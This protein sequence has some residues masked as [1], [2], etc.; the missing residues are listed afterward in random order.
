MQHFWAAMILAGVILQLLVIAALWKG[1][2]REYTLLFVYCIVLLLTTVADASAYFDPQLWTRTRLFWINDA[3]RQVLIFCLVIS[4][5]HRAMG[6]N[7][8]RRRTRRALTAGAVAFTALS[9]LFTWEPAFG[10]WMTKLARNLGFCAV[11]LNLVL[12]A[13]LIKAR[14]TDR[15]LLLISGGLGV[16]MAGKAIGHSLRQMSASTVLAGNLVYVLA[17]LACMYIWWQS[18]RRST[19]TQASRERLSDL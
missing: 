11:I 19:V 12:W 15:R 16:Q 6:G 7:P 1:A 14:D 17:H 3:I 18:F 2:Y 8:G 13:V 9:L 5:I 10:L 4:L